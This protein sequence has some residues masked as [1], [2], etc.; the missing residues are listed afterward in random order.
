MVIHDV[1]PVPASVLTRAKRIPELNSG[2]LQ[3]PYAA[4]TRRALL[5]GSPRSYPH[6]AATA[7]CT[8]GGLGSGRPASERHA[9][10]AHRGLHCK[11]ASRLLSPPV[12]PHRAIVQDAARDVQVEEVDSCQTH[13]LGS[14]RALHVSIGTNAN[15]DYVS[16]NLY[17][18]RQLSCFVTVINWFV[19]ACLTGPS[20][21]CSSSV[22][23]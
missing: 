22:L 15:R 12:L 10:I 7:D 6:R 19:F 5:S 2:T 1:D 4:D 9:E 3:R 20:N 11:A 8:R 23:S 14:L 16:A 13:D 21:G 18:Q 17:L